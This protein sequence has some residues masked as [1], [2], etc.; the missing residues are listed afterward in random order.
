[1]DEIKTVEV[2]TSKISKGTQCSIL[3]EEQVNCFI[4][5]TLCNDL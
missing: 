4:W 5:D 1:M 2:Q 3:D